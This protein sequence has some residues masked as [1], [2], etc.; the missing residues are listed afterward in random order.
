VSTHKS[1]QYVNEDVKK[2]DQA[3]RDAQELLIKVENRA[4]RLKGAI[5]TFT[6]LRDHGQEFTGP[7]SVT[8][9]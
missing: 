2:W 8:D 4:A 5:K 9:I 3:I 1:R 6:E 7:N